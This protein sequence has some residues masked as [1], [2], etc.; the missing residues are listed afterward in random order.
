MLSS[1]HFLEIKVILNFPFPINDVQHEDQHWVTAI[2]PKDQ[3]DSI[4][5]IMF[6]MKTGL[7]CQI[8]SE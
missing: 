5:N 1:S 4:W 6:G 2:P 3:P 7:R 8:P